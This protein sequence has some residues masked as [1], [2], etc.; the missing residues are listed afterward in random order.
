[1]IEDPSK[2]IK[3]LDVLLE[4]QPLIIV[5]GK[6]DK[7]AL[8]RLGFH[9]IIT[10]KKDVD[11]ISQQVALAGRSCAILTDLDPAGRRLYSRLHRVLQ[12]R[13]VRIEDAFRRS[14]LAYSRIR[15]IEALDRYIGSI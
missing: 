13:G 4:S 15:N 8:R 6:K 5:E 14:L 2:I 3:E 12:A 9:H 7:D 11:S 10:L 1:M